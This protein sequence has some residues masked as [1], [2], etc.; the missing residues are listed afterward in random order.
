[1]HYSAGFRPLYVDIDLNN[2]GTS[3]EDFKN[4][5]KI[6]NNSIR[7]VIVQHSFGIPAS[8]NKF[9]EFSREKIYLLSKI[10]LQL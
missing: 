3:F 1:M 8:I 2:L 10:V 6:Y 4:L 7:A 5:Y 9:V